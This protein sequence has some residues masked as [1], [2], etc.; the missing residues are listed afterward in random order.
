[1]SEFTQHV[2]RAALLRDGAGLT[3]RLIE[4]RDGHAHQ[5]A[6]GTRADGSTA[7]R[8]SALRTVS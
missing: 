5:I 7:K 4:T 6:P 2:R 3:D 8:T 1:M